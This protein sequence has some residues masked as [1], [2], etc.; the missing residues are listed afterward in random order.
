M[1]ET[2]GRAEPCII[3]IF[4]ATGDLT[5]RKLLPAI[6]NLTR[7]GLLNENTVI[8][9]FARRPKTDEQFRAD[10][11]E[12]VQKFSRSKPVGPGIWEKI[13]SRL[14]YVQS[15]FEDAQGYQK[16]VERFGQLDK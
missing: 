6:Y 13:A 12:G 1:S 4:G 8:V 10:M 2:A 16:L 11:L 7:D 14:F 5:M 9:G 15:T 3:P